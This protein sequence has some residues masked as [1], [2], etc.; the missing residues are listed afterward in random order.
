VPGGRWIKF[1][2]DPRG[3]LFHTVIHISAENRK[4]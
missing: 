3:F 4:F 1:R 2:F